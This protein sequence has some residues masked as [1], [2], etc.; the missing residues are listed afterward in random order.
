MTKAQIR[1]QLQEIISRNRD[2]KLKG[3]DLSF[4]ISILR[5][6]PNWLEKVGPGLASISVHCTRY[7]NYCFFINRTDGT[8]V[9]ISYLVALKG[10]PKSLE[11]E[12]RARALSAM[13]RC[14]EPLSRAFYLS[15]RHEEMACA[16]CGAP[17]YDSMAHVDHVEPFVEIASSFAGMQGGFSAILTQESRDGMGHSM[18][19]EDMAGDWFAYHQMRATLQILCPTCNMSKGAKC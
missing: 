18:S 15:E 1:R 13:R 3:D 14:V 6:H 9:D 2:S 16:L 7:N 4:A 17:L 19:D 11:V 12:H 10:E 5:S 8:R